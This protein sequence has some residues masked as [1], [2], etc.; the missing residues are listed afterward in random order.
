MKLKNHD[1]GIC[2]ICEK[3]FIVEYAKQVLCGSNICKDSYRRK[4]N[5]K[6]SKERVRLANISKAVELLQSKGYIVIPLG[7]NCKITT[8]P[9]NS[10]NI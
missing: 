8:E 6:R 10:P 1:S 9:L 2:R 5:A 3:V 7:T 4:A